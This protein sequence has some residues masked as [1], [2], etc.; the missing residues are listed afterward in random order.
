MSGLLTRPTVVLGFGRSGRRL[1]AWR[2]RRLA[3]SSNVIRA[4]GAQK[5][6]REKVKT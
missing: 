3:I 2:R 6:K 5:E 4:R 1:A